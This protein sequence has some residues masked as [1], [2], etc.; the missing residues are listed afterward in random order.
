[1][2]ALS[3]CSRVRLFASLWAVAHQAP[4]SMGFSRQEHWGQVPF[5]PPRIKSTP[6]SSPALGG[7]FFLLAPRGKPVRLHEPEV[8]RLP[9]MWESGRPGFDPWVGKIPWRR[10]WQP[11][12]VFL[13]GESPGQRSLV[14]YSQWG[15]KRVGPG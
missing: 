4:L 14:G 11:T 7:G 8:K 15:H 6:L 5:P 10:K 2:C 3:C 12:P 9:A 13:P 1:M